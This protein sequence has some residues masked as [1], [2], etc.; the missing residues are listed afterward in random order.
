M[1]YYIYATN[2]GNFNE[3]NNLLKNFLIFVVVTLR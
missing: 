2:V 3:I 1:V